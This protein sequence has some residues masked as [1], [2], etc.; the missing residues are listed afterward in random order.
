VG[1][2]EGV[3]IATTIANTLSDAITKALAGLLRAIWSAVAIV[4]VITMMGF[5]GLLICGHYTVLR[6][7]AAIERARCQ[8]HMSSKVEASGNVNTITL[9]RPL[10]MEDIVREHVLLKFHGEQHA[11]SNLRS[12][13]DST[14][15]TGTA[16]K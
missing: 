14:R 5:S 3:E 9:P 1:Q 8:C 2:H 12:T 4:L 11:K 7:E 10:T 16:E 13:E 15:P 6:L